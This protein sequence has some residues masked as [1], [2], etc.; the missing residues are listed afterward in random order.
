MDGNLLGQDRQWVNSDTQRAKDKVA[1]M[2]KNRKEIEA[3]SENERKSWIWLHFDAQ[4]T[5]R[6]VF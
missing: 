6:S 3:I 1:T 5:R 4:E 2:L